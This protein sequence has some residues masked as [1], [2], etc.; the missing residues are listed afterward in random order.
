MTVKSG[1]YAASMSCFGK[2]LS[3]DVDSTILHAEKL[4]KDG[5]HGVVLFGST[6]A[7]Q[8]IS[9]Y[10]KEKLIEKIS[11]SEFKDNFLVGPSNNSLNESVELMNRSIKSGINR[12]LIM[13][14][15]YYKYGDDEAY[16]F[17]S[18]LIQRVP[19]CKI[20]LYNFLKLS[21]YQFS[22]QIIEKLVKDFPQQVVGVKDST[23]NLY[24]VLKIPNFLI[25]PG[26]ETKLLKGLELGCS[27]IISAIC[28]V[29]A[30][31]AR[32]VYE[33]FYNKNK[34]THNERL[35][36]IRSIFDKNNL[37][38]GLH[39]FMSIED[40]KYKN[41]LPPLNLLTQEKEKKMISELKVLNFYPKKN[42]VV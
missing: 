13:P 18:N 9:K 32:K 25:F 17:F 20:I 39:S 30:P 10:E 19:E 12:F 40:A 15:A 27:G 37:I 26:S 42:I 14:P 29:T 2:D 6:G 24:E 16:A 41:I 1:I 35:C 34:Q 4:V 3:L 33:D 8:L 36:A 23:Y 28:N 21:G 31:L 38:S 7:G 5:C 11:N 22:T